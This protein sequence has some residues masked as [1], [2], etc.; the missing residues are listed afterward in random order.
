MDGDRTHPDDEEVAPDEDNID[1]IAWKN[2]R[3]DLIRLA[4]LSHS[5][6]NPHGFHCFQPFYYDSVESFA[7]FVLSI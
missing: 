5:A 7:R 6:F 3:S 2:I 1:H 4:T